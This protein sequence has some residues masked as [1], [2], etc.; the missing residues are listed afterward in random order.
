MTVQHHC[1][2]ARKAAEQRRIVPRACPSGHVCP[3]GR[4]QVRTAARAL[5]E[6]VYGPAAAHPTGPTGLTPN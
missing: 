1:M 5:Y 2:G 3:M 4:G 6:R